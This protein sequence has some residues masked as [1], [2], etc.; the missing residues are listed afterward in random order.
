MTRMLHMGLS[1]IGC[2]QC[3]NACPNDIPLAE[4]FK[5][6]GLKAQKGF[7]Y[8]PG[9]SV[10]DPPPLSVFNEDEYQDVTGI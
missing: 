3:S 7:D 9:R 10:D 5:M 8:V 2:G 1:C 4:L 6:V